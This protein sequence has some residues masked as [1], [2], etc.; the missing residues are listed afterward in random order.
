MGVSAPIARFGGSDKGASARSVW[1]FV[2]V[3]FFLSRLLFLGAGA[4]AVLFF[5]QADP[6]GDPLGPGG[7]LGYWANWDGAWYSEVAAGG[8][9]ERAPASTAFFPLYPLLVKLGTVVGGGPV[10]WGV[11]VSLASTLFALFF[12][13]RVAEKLYDARAARAAT[14]CLAF[15]PTAFFLNAVYTEA[16]FLALT[17]GTL[18]AALVRRDLLF[19]GLL[20]ALAAATRN[21]GVLLL[22][23][24]LFEW[25]RH[26]G[27]FGL[28]GAFGVVLVPAGLVAY[29]AY[30]WARFGDPLIFARQQGDYWNREVSG[31]LATL[32]DAWTAAGIGMEYVLDPATL[33][34][35]TDATPALEASNVLNLVFLV[36]F[37]GVAFAGLFVLP[38]GLS[39]YAAALVLLPVL[40]PSPRFPLMSLPRFVLGAF[41]VF[42]VLGFLLSRSPR[43]TLAAWLLFS[44][45]LGVALTALFVTWRWVA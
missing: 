30:L 38:P 13:Y 14:L 9:G 45:G 5:P 19:A 21:V 15:F 8:Y 11:G 44:G 16:L 23:P 3:V 43:W 18:W 26:R 27:E 10:L 37:L 6:A 36:F 28:R 20:G 22:V 32:A 24:L 12:V 34:L 1:A 40:T 2:L 39:V 29:A 4:L 41:P 7:F 33:F 35:G 31:P 42:L 17:A 25:L